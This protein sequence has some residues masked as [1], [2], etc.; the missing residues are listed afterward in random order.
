MFIHY[1]KVAL[2][3][4]FRYKTKHAISILGIAVGFTAFLLGGYWYYWEHSFDTF[5]PDG[6][7]TYIATTSGVMQ[8]VTNGVDAELQQ[9]HESIEKEIAAYPEVKSI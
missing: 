2:R 6:E 4:L 3:N 8:E 1:L 7:H 9:L 5:H